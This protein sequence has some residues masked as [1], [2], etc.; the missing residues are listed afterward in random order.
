MLYMK[1]AP[2]FISALLLGAHFY[3]AGWFPLAVSCTGFPILLAIQ[4]A[5]A[6]RSVQVFLVIGS[7]EWIRTLFMLVDVRRTFGQPWIRLFIILGLVALFTGLSA[8]VLQAPPL[9]SRY[10]L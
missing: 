9:K 8:L 3:R 4:R 1:L 2:I 10:K 5:W 6:A 7:L